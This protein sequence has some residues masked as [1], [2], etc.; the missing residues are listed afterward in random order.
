VEMLF[1]YLTAERNFPCYIERLGQ[2]CGDSF[3][4]VWNISEQYPLMFIGGGSVMHKM[5]ALD[6][7]IDWITVD[8]AAA[9]IKDIMVR[10]AY[11][12]SNEDQSIYH[13]VN[14]NVI[15][16]DDVLQAMKNSGMKFEIVSSSEWVKEL[17]KDDANPAYKLI[18]FYESSFND[19]FKMPI[20]QTEKTSVITPRISKSPALSSTL[21]S[22]FLHHWESVGFYNPSV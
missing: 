1:N 19:T 12:P 20:W 5:P 16:W 11:L 18:G 2:V 7:A 4:G 17:A 14:P 10:T 15:H 21:F 22:K 8:Y 9:A 3:N 13:I 6:T